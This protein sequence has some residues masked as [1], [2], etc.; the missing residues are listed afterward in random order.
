MLAV[1]AVRET[2]GKL[3]GIVTA[4]VSPWDAEQLLEELQQGYSDQDIKKH[5]FELQDGSIAATGYILAQCF[6][7]QP[8]SSVAIAKLFF[9]WSLLLGSLHGIPYAF[10]SSCSTDS[11]CAYTIH[12]HQEQLNAEL[13]SPQLHSFALYLSC[14]G[15]VAT[16]LYGVT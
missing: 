9:G 3:C 11:T 6:T 7:G 13:R 4:A 12:C 16:F 8:S 14:F 10:S 15:D 5:K 1:C 2:A